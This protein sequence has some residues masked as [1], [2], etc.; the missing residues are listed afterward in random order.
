MS[1]AMLPQA[2]KEMVGSES[3]STNRCVIC[4]FRSYVDIPDNAKTTIMKGKKALKNCN[5]WARNRNMPIK[6]MVSSFS[7]SC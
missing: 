5:K 6:F 4:P 1:D 3:I 2:D 7:M